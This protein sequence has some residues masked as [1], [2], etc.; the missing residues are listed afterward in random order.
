[1]NASLFFTII[2]FSLLLMP[3]ALNTPPV[4]TMPGGWSVANPKDENVYEAAKFAVEE[5]FHNYNDFKIVEAYKQVVAGIN[6]DFLI[7]V[8]VPEASCSVHH[9][10]VY[11]RFGTKYLT[12]SDSVEGKKCH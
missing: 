12:A 9:Y 11:D 6:Y 8:T 2:F 10:R 7:D 1:M 5:D 3:V 4:S